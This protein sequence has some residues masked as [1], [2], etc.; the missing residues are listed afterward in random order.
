MA[1][2]DLLLL[3]GMENVV[4]LFLGR[5][6]EEETPLFIGESFSLPF[7]FSSYPSLFSPCPGEQRVQTNDLSIVILAFKNCCSRKKEKKRRGV[8]N[9]SLFDPFFLACTSSNNNFVGDS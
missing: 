2:H 4:G 8:N 5:T 6:Q 7:F 3:H 1:I 9:L